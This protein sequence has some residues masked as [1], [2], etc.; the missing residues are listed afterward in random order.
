[1][2]ALDDR[3]HDGGDAIIMGAAPPQPTAAQVRQA[4]ERDEA[5]R[6]HAAAEE[7]ERRAAEIPPAHIE[8][9]EIVRVRPS[10][11]VSVREAPEGLVITIRP[12]TAYVLV[13]EDRPDAEG[14]TGLMLLWPTP[15]PSTNRAFPVY[16]RALPKSEPEPEPPPPWRPPWL[17]VAEAE[18]WAAAHETPNTTTTPPG[19]AP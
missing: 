18:Q 7:R 13:P 12:S 19:G 2:P 5:R 8:A 17:T 10:E 14:K 6:A 15:S 11:I 3:P 1:M 16:A 9:A 4:R